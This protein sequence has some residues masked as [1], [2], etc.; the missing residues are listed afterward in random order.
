M[1][2]FKP[3]E[4]EEQVIYSETYNRIL[5]FIKIKNFIKQEISN[6]KDVTFI[7]NKIDRFVL[8]DLKNKLY[9]VV[10]RDLIEILDNYD[11]SGKTSSISVL[12]HYKV[13]ED[14]LKGEILNILKT[15]K[16]S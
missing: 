4:Q 9:I 7:D 12:E 5:N 10:Q 15:I 1:P 8:R 16:E 2:F 11:I 3:T 6:R 13:N 14:N